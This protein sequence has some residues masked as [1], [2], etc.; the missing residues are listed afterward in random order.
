MSILDVIKHNFTV[1]GVVSRK[2]PPSNDTFVSWAF[3]KKPIYQMSCDICKNDYWGRYNPKY[4]LCGR[5]DCYLK[6]KK[7]ASD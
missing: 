3:L 7:L 5:F 2:D 1:Y 4:Q 6:N